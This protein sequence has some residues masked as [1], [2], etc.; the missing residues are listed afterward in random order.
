MLLKDILTC[1]QK[2]P[3]MQSVDTMLDALS[4]RHKKTVWISIKMH[5]C[6]KWQE[7]ISISVTPTLEHRPAWSLRWIKQSTAQSQSLCAPLLLPLKRFHLPW[8]LIISLS[9]FQSF[10]FFPFFESSLFFATSS[11]TSSILPVFLSLLWLQIT[12]YWLA[13]CFTNLLNSSGKHFVYSHAQYD[14]VYI[15]SKNDGISTGYHSR[16]LGLES[17]LHT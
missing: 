5:K 13:H 11:L 7:I 14:F 16:S 3:T 10:I 9:I 12:M 8:H 17:Y 2:E 6:I 4:H 15:Y 1:R